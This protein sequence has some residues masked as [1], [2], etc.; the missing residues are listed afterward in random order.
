M[1]FRSDRTILSIWPWL[2]RG[3]AQCHSRGDYFLLSLTQ[4]SLL[5]LVPQ[6]LKHPFLVLFLR[7]TMSGDTTQVDVEH[8]VL[9]PS[10]IQGK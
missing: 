2:T 10:P 9:L 3:S 7:E 1:Q 5:P 4:S 8:G 6:S